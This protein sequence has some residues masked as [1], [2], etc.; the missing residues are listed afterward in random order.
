MTIIVLCKTKRFAPAEGGLNTGIIIGDDSV[1]VADT[2]A[3]PIMAQ[4]STTRIRQ[5]TEIKQHG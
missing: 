5:A 3:T 1:L 2:Q 4:D